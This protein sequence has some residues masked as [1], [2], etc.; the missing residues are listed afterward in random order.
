MVSCGRGWDEGVE[1][2]NAPF[3]A[4]GK[5]AQSKQRGTE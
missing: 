5:E 2:G 4:Q 1:K 3:E